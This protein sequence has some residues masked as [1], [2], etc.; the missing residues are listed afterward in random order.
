MLKELTSTKYEL[1][2]LVTTKQTR[3]RHEKLLKY[4]DQ[5][6]FGNILD[7]GE[8]NPFTELLE[9]KFNVTIDNT[10]G[11]LDF[12]EIPY[13]KKYD[14]ILYLDV[15]EHQMNPL[16][17]LHQISRILKS[18]GKM[19]ITTPRRGKLLW[20]KGHFHEFDKYRFELMMKHPKV[21]FEIVAEH[22][23]KIVRNWWTYFL[24]F[25]PL[26]RLF[27]EYGLIYVV[28]KK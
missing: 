7:V 28:R 1:D 19:Y 12:I 9:K 21:N 23:Y 18:D 24:G 20:A 27:F 13:D 11:D 3:D 16:W 5:K 4:F 6:L 22:K 25:R 10:K 14:T 15:I 26:L 17:T 8:R 2:K